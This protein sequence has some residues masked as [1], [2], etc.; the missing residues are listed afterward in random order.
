MYLRFKVINDRIKEAKELLQQDNITF[1]QFSR[2]KRAYKERISILKSFMYNLD[3]EL[4]QLKEKIK[5]GI[6]L[7]ESIPRKNECIAEI[8]KTTKIIANHY[9]NYRKFLNHIEP[10]VEK[11]MNEAHASLINNDLSMKDKVFDGFE[12][13]NKSL[14]IWNYANLVKFHT[15][16]FYDPCFVNP[17]NVVIHSSEF[18]EVKNILEQSKDILNFNALYMQYQKRIEVL[19]QMDE[20]VE[21][22]IRRINEVIDSSQKGYNP[23]LEVSLDVY[24]KCLVMLR[25]RVKNAQNLLSYYINNVNSLLTKYDVKVEAY[26]QGTYND[27]RQAYSKYKEARRKNEDKDSLDK[28]KN[29]MINTEN[30]V[31]GW[32]LHKELIRKFKN[33]LLV[34]PYY[35]NDNNE[36]ELNL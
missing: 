12:E 1:E 27:V 32:K 29:K 34:E 2:V 11:K 20:T 24:V 14:L 4:S 9:S 10:I 8:E 33:T 26:L 36:T 21:T 18:K 25:E 5:N 13:K 7:N 17:E 31:H 19:N 23:N 22:Y 30:S 3:Q 28:I 35:N 6:D 16:V 15:E